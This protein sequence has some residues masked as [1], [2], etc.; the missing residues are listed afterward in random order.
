MART[1]E[2][3]PRR[4]LL[5]RRRESDRPVACCSREILTEDPLEHG[6]GAAASGLAHELK[7][8]NPSGREA[9]LTYNVKFELKKGTSPSLAG[10]P[11]AA[12]GG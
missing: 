11:V 7:Y 2:A 12:Y 5:H 9:S 3:T 1:V 6:F 4:F 8:V 10:A